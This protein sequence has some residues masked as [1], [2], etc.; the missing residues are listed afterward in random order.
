MPGIDKD[1]WKPYNNLACI[2][3][4]QNDNSKAMALLNNANT[5]LRDNPII[6]NNMGVASL[7]FNDPEKALKYFE[8]TQKFGADVDYNIGMAYLM[9]G[10]YSEA[11]LMLS[12]FSCRY[13]TYLSFFSLREYEK[14]LQ[15]QDC[16]E[17]SADDYY[18]MA[19]AYARL[20]DSGQM[21]QNLSSAIALDPDMRVKALS[22]PEFT[23]YKDIE[24][25]RQ[26]LN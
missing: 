18:L 19:L 10:Q 8:M 23:E 20:K 11:K 1:D 22:D 7:R 3:L 13:N 16:D 12:K 14:V 6:L 5:R 17:L 25:F 15:L 24:D 9:A 2:S 21:L 4:E 26:L